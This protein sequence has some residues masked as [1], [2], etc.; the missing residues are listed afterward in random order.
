MRKKLARLGAVLMILGGMIYGNLVFGS[1]EVYAK[2]D[3]ICNSD[4]SDDVKEAAGCNVGTGKVSNIVGV[5][6]NTLMYIAGALAVVM[7]IY[8]GFMY[9]TS[10]GDSAKVTKAKN[11]LIYA[12]VGVIIAILAGVIVRFVVKAV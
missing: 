4:M 10:A 5:A 9:M 2:K 8:S 3:A 7:I 11:A 1:S 6:V 12:V